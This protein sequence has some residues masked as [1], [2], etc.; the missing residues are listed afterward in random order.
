MRWQE[1]APYLEPTSYLVKPDGSGCL[2]AM[3]REVVFIKEG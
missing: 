1:Q 3:G 2:N